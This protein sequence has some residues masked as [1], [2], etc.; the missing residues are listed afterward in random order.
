MAYDYHSPYTSSGPIGER[1]WAEK[2]IRYLLSYI[3]SSKILLGAPSYGYCWRKG[4]VRVISERKAFSLSVRYPSSL[5][6]ENLRISL[7]DGVCFS[8]TPSLRRSYLDLVEKYHLK[9]IAIWRAGL[10]KEFF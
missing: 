8:S 1:K 3:S 5:L 9:G 7:P 10:E 4:K 2:N 6:Q